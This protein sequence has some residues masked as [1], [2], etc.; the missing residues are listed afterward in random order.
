MK[1]S[2][3]VTQTL[4]WL[5][6]E[7]RI[8]YRAL[9]REFDLDDEFLADLKDEIIEAKRLAVDE[10]GKVLVWVGE[11]G[12]R[13]A[14][15]EEREKAEL[16]EPGVAP[17]PT[18]HAQRSD[19]ERR[20]L[21]VMFCD[22]VGSTALSARLDPEDLREVVRQYQQRCAEV[23][24]RHEGYI[25]QYLG[26]G[27]LV[28][29]GYP[30]AHEDDVRR[31]V[32][33]GLE[34]VQA[35][36]GQVTGDGGQARQQPLQVRIG[37]HT[38]LV[39]IGD[40]GE[41]GR[42]EQLALG[43]T[44]NIAARIQ[45]L[46]E[47]NTVII[48]AATQRL[49]EGQFESQP[50]GSHLV[51]GIETPITVYHVQNER[52]GASLLAG[53]I[54]LTPLVGREQEVGLLV[55][56]WEQV[57]EGRGQVVLLSGEPG[58]GK[59]RLAYVLREQVTGEGSLF[60]EARCSPYHQH[61]AF[62]PLIDVLQWTLLLTRQDTNEE[63]IAKLDLAL[64]LYGMR[65]SLPLFAALLSLST[66]SQ[67]QPL[68][69]TP[70]K[71]K[72]RTLQALMQLLV[73]Q[74]EQQAIVS[75]WEDLHWADP[76]SL[77]FLSLLIEQI[78]TTKLL[79]VLTFRPEFRPPWKPRSHISQLVLN[80]LGKKQVEAMIE[81]VTEGKGLPAD[82]VEQIRVK[83]DGV[84][85]FVEELTKS[86]IESVESIG[87]I[88]SPNRL[89][90]QLAIPA[91]LQET[92]LARLDRLSGAR[93]V[94]QLGATLGREFS[95]ELIR[96]V[97]TLNET[98]LHAA[99]DKLVEA[100]ILYRRGIREQARYFFKHALIQDTAYQ[101]LLKST[102]QQYHQQIAKVLE[103]RFTEAKETQPE[104]LAHHYTEASLIEQAIPYWQKAGERA[105]Q[106]SA[107]T[108]AIS[109]LTKGLEL[110]RTQLDTPERTQQELA[111][112][113]A[114]GN[115]LMATKG[116]A[117][118]EVEEVY[119]RALDL[120]RQTEEPP[121]LF[122]VLVG[123]WRLYL[124]RAEHK[125][126]RELGEQCLSL[127]QRGHNPVRLLGAHQSLGVTFFYLGEL[128]QARAHL[129]Q[130]LTFY[131]PQKHRSH[132][133]RGG[134]DPAVA[135]L[136][137][138]AWAL[139]SLGYPD[140][141]LRRSHE[142]L[143]LAQELSHPLSL[144]QALVSILRIHQHYREGQAAQE[145]AE[146]LMTLSTDQGFAFTLAWGTIMRGWAAAEQGRGE[147]GT[148]QVRQGL[149]ASRATGAEAVRPYWLALLAEAYGQ[150]GQTEAGLNALAE[151]LV[152]VDKTEEREYEAELYRLKG[153]LTLQGAN[154]K[155]KGKN[156]KAKIGTNPQ[157]LTPSTQAEVEREAEEC[158]LKAIE[159]ARK[160]Q[161][162]SW[163]L[164]AS[165]SLARLWQQQGKKV[166]AHRLLSD[167]YKWFTEGFDT[168][169]LQEAKTLLEELA[170]G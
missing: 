28:Y 103:G 72:E 25:A 23:I 46:A 14:K 76:S 12:E 140:Q 69:L 115:S 22:L 89:P 116:Y 66:P 16:K 106:R 126:A 5:Q 160:Q 75:V 121:R 82:T 133:F 152:A 114:L 31:A 6:R 38:G 148:A 40:I 129:E 65:E 13:K 41:S 7:G 39:V 95:Y 91:T 54:S 2:E 51:K 36:R 104:L 15:S 20:Q 48:S 164:R 139:W 168:R 19:G 98:D 45:G 112:Q 97:A 113:M 109:H 154:Q 52:E 85:L 130:A 42:T 17:R 1:F 4:D 62:Y 27:L 122:P 77:E 53:R 149:A 94:A 32:R 50:F 30:T 137:Q 86:V 70:Q 166:E 110:L 21:T 80:R 58:I 63:K 60:F 37:I 61:S 128:A 132:V 125:R 147:E 156:Q 8:S 108:E 134:Q 47:P 144:A 100:E 68:T 101:S 150:M 3:V 79:L 35:I 118:P 131:D 124:T 92:L 142:A 170:E 18:L 105:T 158:F 136:T 57:K 81:K 107:N 55:D 119:T 11:A 157:P 102:R 64:T 34:I 161:A 99:L 145:R 88:E 33:A 159:I 93:Q 67:Y 24:Q 165:T 10:N 123:L 84:P 26:D 120:C 155:A 56:R 153:E 29:F 167:V 59:S 44:P 9:K 74:A 141:A 117:A 138:V 73:V 83:T 162:K 151:A 169:D 96:A 90:L 71:Q 135:C 143:I 146:A 78:P 87:S 127:A 111:L 49:I 163:E 43:E